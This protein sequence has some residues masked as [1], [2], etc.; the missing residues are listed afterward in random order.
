MVLRGR[1]FL[2]GESKTCGKCQT[3]VAEVIGDTWGGGE[4]RPREGQGRGGG[5]SAW[6][7]VVQQHESVR[8][9]KSAREGYARSRRSSRFTKMLLSVLDFRGLKT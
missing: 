5:I 9:R 4:G 2:D 7:G 6:R 3:F 1:R 8:E